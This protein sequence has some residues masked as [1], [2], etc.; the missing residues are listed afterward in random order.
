MEGGCAEDLLLVHYV[1]NDLSLVDVIAIQ[2]LNGIDLVSLLVIARIHLAKVPRS[3]LLHY[4]KIRYNHLLLVALFQVQ[5]VDGFG[6]ISLRLSWFQLKV[7]GQLRH[8]PLVLSSNILR[9]NELLGDE[10]LTELDDRVLVI[11]D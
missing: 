9:H 2:H 8:K 10:K 1:L 4:M 3:Q 7:N 11:G 5:L 6:Q